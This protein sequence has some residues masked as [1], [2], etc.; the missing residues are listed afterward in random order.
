MSSNNDNAMTRFLF[1]ILRQKNLKDIDWNKV[2]HDPILAQ[3]ITNGH[4]ARMRYSRFRSAMLGLEPTKRNRTSSPK[5]RVTK[6]KKDS[7][8][9]KNDTIKPESPVPGLSHS[10]SPEAPQSTSQKIKQESSSYAYNSRMTPALTPGPVSAPPAAI[11]STTI[12]HNRFLTPCSDIDTFGASPVMASSPTSDMLQSQ[13]S[14]D[15]HAPPCPD[16]VD[17]AW[18]Q[19]TSYFAAAYPF[20]EYNSPCDHQHLQHSLHSQCALGLPSQSI[21]GE[22]EQADVKREDWTRYD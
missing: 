21:E 18:T 2:A 14:F 15:F 17:P 12:L 11:P 13:S 4:A 10:A 7:K 19:G 3:P 5:G 22:I 16:H 9:K 8:N 6:P 1:A 20:D